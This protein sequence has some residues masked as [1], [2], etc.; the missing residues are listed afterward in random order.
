MINRNDVIK[1]SCARNGTEKSKANL[2]VDEEVV[3]RGVLVIGVLVEPLVEPVV[4]VYS[5][6]KRSCKGEVK[7]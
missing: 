3:E 1:L 7:I 2:L 5:K 6:Q 4:E